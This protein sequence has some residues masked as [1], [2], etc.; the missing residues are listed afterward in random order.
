MKSIYKK[1]KFPS[2]PGG[3]LY[4]WKSAETIFEALK[5]GL[6]AIRIDMGEDLHIIHN[7]EIQ[8]YITDYLK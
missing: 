1:I 7:F 5:E 4:E 8:I 3:N 2:A 6:H